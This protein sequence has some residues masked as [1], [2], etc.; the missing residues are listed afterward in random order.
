MNHC[1]MSLL[2]CWA[3]YKMDKPLLQFLGV[4]AALTFGYLVKEKGS[5]SKT[6]GDIGGFIAICGVQT[7]ALAYLAMQ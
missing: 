6:G 4:T 7:A 1:A 3:I 5:F 2:K